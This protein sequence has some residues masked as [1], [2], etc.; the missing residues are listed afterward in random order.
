MNI[1]AEK[2]N[3]RDAVKKLADTARESLLPTKSRCQY[4][5]TYQEYRAWCSD[6]KIEKTNEDSILAYFNSS[7]ASYKSSSLWTK[8]SMLRSTIK[9]SEGID[10][11][12]YPSVIVYLKRKSEGYK[13]KKSLSLLKENVDKFI[14][15]ADEKEHLLNKVIFLVH[16]V[17]G[18]KIMNL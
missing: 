10:I 8:Y 15:E 13:A 9:L 12:K 4:N 6:N 1:V 11:S 16:F 5:R 18:N 7:L 3:V 17:N 14:S 2:E